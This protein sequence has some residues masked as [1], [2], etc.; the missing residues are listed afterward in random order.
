MEDFQPG[1][2]DQ[3][4]ADAGFVEDRAHEGLVGRES[5][6]LHLAEIVELEQD[7]LVAEREPVGEAAVLLQDDVGGGVEQAKLARR[8]SLPGGVVLVMAAAHLAVVAVA[9]IEPDVAGGA[10]TAAATSCCR[11]TTGL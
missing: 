3:E 9:G 8:L 1:I 6:R 11:T 7:T 4:E 10:P 2:V 5:R